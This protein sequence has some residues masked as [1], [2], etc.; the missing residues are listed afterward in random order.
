MDSSW[1][2]YG[3]YNEPLAMA[4]RWRC[5]QRRLV[6]GC[7]RLVRF[8]QTAL[9]DV[10]PTAALHKDRTGCSRPFNCISH[11][12]VRRQPRRAPY[13]LVAAPREHNNHVQIT[14]PTFI[15]TL[16]PHCS[17][18][19]A[20]VAATVLFC[21]WLSSDLSLLA[22][23]STSASHMSCPSWGWEAYAGISAVIYLTAIWGMTGLNNY[24]A[25]AGW[26]ATSA[27]CTL[28]FLF[29]RNERRAQP[30]RCPLR[31]DDP[32]TT[33][34][35]TTPHQHSVPFLTPTRRLPFY[36]TLWALTAMTAIGVLLLTLATAFLVLS[37]THHAPLTGQSTWMAFISFTM[38]VKCSLQL[39]ASLCRARRRWLVA[40][41]EQH[42]DDRK[43]RLIDPIV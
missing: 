39:I 25:A 35:F 36:C 14:H 5:G 41:M 15:T 1:K 32:K 23:S 16:P 18:A 6:E 10:G 34:T 30:L 2:H 20:A 33:A 42:T 13:H 28:W 43:A 17:A 29:F 27:V 21:C 31:I 7:R 22:M 40:A 12:V 11:N 37:I 4:M 24:Y 3:C 38:S 8:R 19:A 9:Q 26:G